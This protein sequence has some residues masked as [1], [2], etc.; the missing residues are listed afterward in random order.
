VVAALLL[1]DADARPG[2]R[3][4]ADRIETARLRLR[5]FEPA[6]LDSLCEMTSDPEVMRFIG[7]GQILTREETRSNLESIIAA[8][9]RRG[10]GR[11][12]LESKATGRLVGYCGLS[13]GEE[14]VGVELAY[15]LARAEWGRGLA[16]EAG[17]ACVRYAFERLGL[18]S[19]AGLTLHD[20]SRSRRVLERLGMSLVGDAHFYGFD[21]VHYLLARADWRADG[22]FYRV[23]S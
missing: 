5:M 6:D 2:P 4:T 13:L 20:N 9:R 3:F 18:R 12:A 15:L 11:W 10:F 22:S 7:H 14:E 16:L 8:F 1:T 21:C 17:R 23:V 19:V